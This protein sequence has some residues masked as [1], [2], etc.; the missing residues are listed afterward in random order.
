[1]IATKHVNISHTA[2][3]KINL[4]HCITFFDDDI[5]NI[6]LNLLTIN[7]KC[8]KN[9]DIVSYETKYIIMQNING[10]NT[11]GKV[12]L[13]LKFSGLDAYFIED[14]ENKYLLLALTL[15]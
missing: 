8:I 13:F 6:D 10:H 14:N 1:M 3:E 2:F 4:N 11:D 9:T 7:T 15:E 5:K 12:P